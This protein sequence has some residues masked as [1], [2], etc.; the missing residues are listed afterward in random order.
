MNVR[1]YHIS[2]NISQKMQ[3]V[4]LRSLETDGLIV[5]KL[6]AEVPP[7]VEYEL[8]ALGSSLVPYIESLADWALKNKETI[9]KHRK[10]YS[11]HL[12]NKN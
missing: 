1:L 10:K 6:Y 3:T 12:Q 7:R 9:T 2:R 5:R 8:T 11:K 4:S